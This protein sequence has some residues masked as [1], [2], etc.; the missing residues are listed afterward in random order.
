MNTENTTPLEQWIEETKKKN[1]SLK[2][3]EKYIRNSL[4]CPY[5]IFLNLTGLDSQDKAERLFAEW[6]NK[7]KSIEKWSVGS[8]VVLIEK[9]GG[10]NVG[11]THEID[12]EHSGESC[13]SISKSVKYACFPFKNNCKWFA[14]KSEAEEFAKTLVKP[15]KQ[16]AEPMTTAEELIAEAKRRY[17]IGTKFI[18]AHVSQNPNYFCIVCTTDFRYEN[19]YLYAVLPDD[20]VYDAQNNPE[21]GNCPFSRVI[22]YSKEWA[23]ILPTENKPQFEVGKWYQIKTAYNWIIKY[24]RTDGNTIKAMW[25]CLAEPGNKV[26]KE[27]TWSSKPT[28]VKELSIEEIQQ[29]LPDNHPD[30]IKSNPE[31]KVG[32]YVVLQYSSAKEIGYNTTSNNTRLKAGHI[33]KIANFRDGQTWSENSKIRW[34]GLENEPHNGVIEILLRH[35]TQEEINNHL[36]SI[37][38]IQQ[39]LLGNQEFKVGDWVVW[40][41]DYIDTIKRHCNSF[42]DSWYLSEKYNSCSELALRHAT[43]KEVNDHLFSTKLIIGDSV[44]KYIM[45]I[46]AYEICKSNLLLSIDDEELPMVSIIKTNST[47]LLNIE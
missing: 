36:I 44:G 29:Y 22:F 4:S 8:S 21:Y 33:D 35:A 15:V 47:K 16:E 42:A 12:N 20:T 27:G 9:Y 10:I 13:I 14:T 37:G 23:T 28:E 45:G 32:D 24:E 41:D 26:K 40:S 11:E 7:P 3:L 31:F 38:Q 5:D 19:D 34:V 17:S 6:K 2:D 30:K 46:D 43:A 1:L 25:C 39:Y 18:P